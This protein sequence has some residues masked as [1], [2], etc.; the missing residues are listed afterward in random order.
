MRHAIWGLIV[1]VGFTAMLTGWPADAESV[2]VNTG[3]PQGGLITYVQKFESRPTSV[4]IIDPEQRTMAVYYVGLEKGHIELK[5][6]RNFTWDLG[7]TEHNSN[8][9]LPLEIRNGLQRQ[10]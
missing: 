10:Q 3:T 2:G 4:I 8:K 7:M 1:G 9:P 5:S 6:V